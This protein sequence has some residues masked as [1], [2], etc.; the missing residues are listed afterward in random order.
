[1]LPT[2]FVINPKAGRSTLNKL[3]SLLRHRFSPTICEI[4]TTT[5]ARE[6]TDIARE[7]ART[8]P[9]VV[10]VGGDG[11]INEVSNGL[12]GTASNLGILP[13]GSG[14]DF[15]RTLKLPSTLHERIEVLARQKVRAIDV[16]KII[17]TNNRGLVT[18]R[19]FVNAVGIGLDAQV[20]Y[21]AQKVPRIFGTAKYAISA[22]RCLF[23]YTPEMTQVLFD[24]H[25]SVGKHN[26]ISIGNGRS[27]GGGFY[28]T[29]K[30]LL[31]DGL[32]DV[33]IARDLSLV[34]TL[35]VFPFVLFGKHG[36]FKKLT[37]LKTKRIAISSPR[38]LF[39]HVDGEVLA[40]DQ[41]SIEVELQG[42]KLGV[43]VP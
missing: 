39:V 11:T 36:I 29:P 13:T 42:L 21:E 32:L 40:I 8:F 16:G 38:D 15:A 1:M 12:V 17:A 3:V 4:Y 19:H 22:F 23:K 9:F 20:A 6:A 7:A 30:A 14:N 5:R 34:E 33:C 35:L 24:E 27:A 10:A 31:D 25:K 2:F 28:L 18:S 41:R 43:I 26:L 37:L